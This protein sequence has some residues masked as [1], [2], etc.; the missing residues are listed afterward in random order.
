MSVM[1]IFASNNPASQPAIQ[2]DS[3]RSQTK[4]NKTPHNIYTKCK[5]FWQSI[6]ISH[7]A[8]IKQ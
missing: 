6:Q 1:S 5:G 8:E 4:Q 3:Q 2:A 7:G